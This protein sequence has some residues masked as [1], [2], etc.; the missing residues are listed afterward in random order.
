MDRNGNGRIDDGS[1]L[2]GNYTPAVSGRNAA[3]GFEALKALE[4][5]TYGASH[6]DG[7]FD[8]RDAP[9]PRLLL[10]RDANHNGISE[11]DELTPAAAAGLLSIAT[12]YKTSGRRD[13]HGNEFR[14]RAK[15]LWDDGEFFMYDVWLKR[16]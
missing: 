6:P 4:D 8:S 9:F 7:R 1:E 15:G 13:R 2:F 11:P 16:Q 10:W 3:N 14:Q 12:D 5:P